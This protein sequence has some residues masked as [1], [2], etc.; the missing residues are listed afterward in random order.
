MTF[1]MLWM[2]LLNK[3][4]SKIGILFVLQKYC[5]C[6]TVNIRCCSE[7]WKLNLTFNSP[8]ESR[9]YP[10]EGG[11]L[12]VACG[13]WKARYFLLG[14]NILHMAV[15]HNPLFG[16]FRPD[17]QLLEVENLRLVSLVKKNS[18]IQI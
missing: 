10:V 15:D 1:D 8:T 6:A 9:Y 13:L 4:W 5:K 18:E 14:V 12:D 2:T 7:G 3:D 16:L 11:A 17:H